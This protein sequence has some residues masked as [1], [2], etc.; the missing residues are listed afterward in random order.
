[1]HFR[2]LHLAAFPDVKVVFLPDSGKVENGESE[3]RKLIPM[4]SKER[5]REEQLPLPVKAIARKRAHTLLLSLLSFPISQRQKTNKLDCLT[6]LSAQA[7]GEPSRPSAP[8]LQTEVPL[9]LS[10]SSPSSLT[11][12]NSEN[13]TGELEI[14]SFFPFPATKHTQILL[15]PSGTHLVGRGIVFCK[16][17]ARSLS[18]RQL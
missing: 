14:P 3:R 15:L 8:S 18:P 11:V 7:R 4:V 5:G 2:K 17:L 9:L 10:S 13:P 16:V 12:D 1:M 6:K